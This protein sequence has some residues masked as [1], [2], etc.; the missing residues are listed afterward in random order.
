M[1]MIYSILNLISVE[2]KAGYNNILS[3]IWGNYFLSYLCIFVYAFSLIIFSHF[4]FLDFSSFC[5]ILPAKFYH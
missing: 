3:V 4:S 2:P 1:Y 5:C